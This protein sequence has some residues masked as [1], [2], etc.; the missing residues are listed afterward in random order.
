MTV[1]DQAKGNRI[2]TLQFCSAM[3]Y[4]IHTK[5]ICIH[6]VN[7]NDM[8]L[9]SLFQDG[10]QC[11][12]E[13]SRL[14]VE[15]WKSQ[16]PR[17]LEEALTQK[18]LLQEELVTVRARMCDVSLVSNKPRACCNVKYHTGRKRFCLSKVGYFIIFTI[19][20][21]LITN[22]LFYSFNDVIVFSQNLLSLC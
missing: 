7:N 17:A 16:G 8:K 11:A 19:I 3:K 18:A 4:K 21:L 6:L 14:Q 12:L 20:S 9:M 5:N 13:V 1:L 10:V 22:L 15:E 2:G